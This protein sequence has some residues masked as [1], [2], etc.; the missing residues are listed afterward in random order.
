MLKPI[1]AR[2]ASMVLTLIGVAI[3]VFV[4]IRVAPGNPIAMML[5]PG[6]TQDDIAQ[7]TAMY[8]LD[9]SLFQQFV[10]WAGNALQG[11]FGTS[12]TL[13]QPVSELVL[14]RLP[15]TL[16]LS[17]LALLIA[18]ALGGATAV[19]GARERGRGQEAGVDLFNGITLSIPDFLWGLLLIL[20][21]GVMWP[22]LHISGRVSPH[23]DLPFV[24]QF[25]LI[26]GLL[27]L[28]WDLVADLLAHMIMPALALALPLAAIISQLLKQGL[29]EVLELDYAVLARVRG[30][31]ETQVILREALRNAALPT[32]TLIGVQFTFLIGGTVIVERLFAYEGLGN[33]AI[34]AVINRDLPLIQGIVLTFA[35]LFIL[36]NLAVDLAYTFLNPRLRHG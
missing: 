15:A 24:T 23:L 8:G 30:F 32:L 27:R 9:K 22:V 29:K 11:D 31:T 6:A 13:R 18:V 35:G 4:L 20:V 25:Y 36:I 21:F 10:I 1:L 19:L 28:R 16:E 17:L 34:D 26:E 5:P 33:M 2:L 7:L 14:D 3:V 12:I